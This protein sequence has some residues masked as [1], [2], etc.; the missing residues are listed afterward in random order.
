M[1]L[2]LKLR[3]S[4]LGTSRP[5]SGQAIDDENNC[6]SPP[7]TATSTSPLASCRALVTAASSRFS[8]EGLPLARSRRDA[9]ARRVLQQNAVDHRFDGV[10]LAP[11]Q[12]YRL[13]QVHQLAV[14]AGA[15]ALPVELVEQLLELALASAHD[16]RH[17]RDALA[18]AQFQNPLHNLAEYQR[19][20]CG[21]VVY[22]VGSYALFRTRSGCCR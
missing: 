19:R 9:S 17:H 8:A 20:V 12:V 4:S 16:R 1:E 13:R 2:K 11:V 10:V 5:Q 15:E 7:V 18:P 3:G 22:F 14:H 21:F 6:S